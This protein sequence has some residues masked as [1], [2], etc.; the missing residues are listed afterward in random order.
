MIL[1]NYR[2][3]LRNDGIEARLPELEQ[4][5]VQCSV[6]LLT[7]CDSANFGYS[8]KACWKVQSS[9]REERKAEKGREGGR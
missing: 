2:E 8:V 3:T 7:Y 9:E 4:G 5:L 6:F 1:S